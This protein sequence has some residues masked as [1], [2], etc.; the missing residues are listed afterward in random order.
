MEQENFLLQYVTR[1]KHLVRFYTQTMIKVWRC[2]KFEF[3]LRQELKEVIVSM[4]K[5][6]MMEGSSRN[7]PT[8]EEILLQISFFQ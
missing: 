5:P 8:L 2:K 1:F 7:T 4:S 6:H 3:G